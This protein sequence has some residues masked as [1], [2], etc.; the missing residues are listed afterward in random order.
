MSNYLIPKN[1][2]QRGCGNSRRSN[3]RNPVGV[4]AQFHGQQN[5]RTQGS[6]NKISAPRR[7]LRE[8]LAIRSSGSVAR[9]LG[10]RQD[11]EVVPAVFLPGG[12]IVARD[13]GLIL[14]IA[15]R[16]DPSGVDAQ[17]D[18]FFAHGQRPP[19][20]KGTVV[21][22]RAALVAVAFNFHRDDRVGLQII[23]HCRHFGLLGGF[24]N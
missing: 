8:A 18:K 21:F 6:A 9:L 1:L 14:A 10:R 24:K 4:D 3:G 16:I 12:F 22:L 7:R 20:A 23:G 5:A 2:C 17:A 13:C 19:L 11:D 15:D